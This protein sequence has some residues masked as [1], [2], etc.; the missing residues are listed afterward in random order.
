MKI[1]IAGLG[2]IGRRHLRN[3]VRLGEQD[4]LLFRTHHATL[5]DEELAGYPVVTDLEKALGQKPDA[6]VISNPT[7]LH[8]SVALPCAQ[9]GC[10]LFL[11]KPLSVDCE[12]LDELQDVLR[13]KGNPALVGFQFRFHPAFCQIAQWIKDGLVGKIYSAEVYWGE[14]LPDWH[15]W[16]DYRV[17]YSA[18]K[19]LGGGVLLTLC[20]PIDY[21]RWLLGEV[22]SVSGFV[23]QVS[24]LE[25]EV[26]DVA[27]IRMRHVS[28][29]YSHIHLDYFTRPKRHTLQIIGSH[30]SISWDETSNEIRLYQPNEKGWSTIRPPADFERNDLFLTEMRHFLNVIKQREKPACSIADG[31]RV[32]QIIMAAYQ[33]AE[34]QQLEVALPEIQGIK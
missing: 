16:E 26:E 20:H 7:A 30:A 33:S 13:K 4:I 21:I 28:G 15:P 14:Y 24:D 31:I 22:K 34:Q 6:A 9:A 5:A 10:A 19:E 18:R 1:L 11:E 29:A 17:S 8:L 25:L 27:D 23:S 12:G 3:L 32:Q 2:S